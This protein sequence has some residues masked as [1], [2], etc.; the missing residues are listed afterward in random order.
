M[1]TYLP[2][3]KN[4]GRKC[5]SWWETKEECIWFCA[6]RFSIEHNWSNSNNSNPRKACHVDVRIYSHHSRVS[7]R[8]GGM[9]SQ[10]NTRWELPLGNK[11]FSVLK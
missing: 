10:P 4:L 8:L 11:C 1:H 3:D 2:T 5:L 9:T 7:Q 6:T